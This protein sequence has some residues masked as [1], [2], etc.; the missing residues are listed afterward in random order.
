MPLQVVKPRRPPS[1]DSEVMH[2]CIYPTTRQASPPRYDH[3]TR[4]IIAALVYARRRVRH[5][6]IYPT[7]RQASPPRDF[8]AANA[9]HRTLGAVREAVPRDA[10][11]NSQMRLADNGA[12]GQ[13]VGAG[14]AGRRL[15]AGTPPCGSGW[16]PLGACMRCTTGGCGRWRGALVSRS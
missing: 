2:P 16:T 13:G 5:P 11:A 8:R 3:I 12:A 6:C 7:T 4:I 1:M 10:G 15:E 14:S 9:P